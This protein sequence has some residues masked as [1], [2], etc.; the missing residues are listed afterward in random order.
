MITILSF[1]V[2]FLNLC[3]CLPFRIRNELVLLGIFNNYAKPGLVG[4]Q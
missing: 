1:F 4:V 3:V 2:A